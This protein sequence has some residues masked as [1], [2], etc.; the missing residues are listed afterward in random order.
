MK[1]RSVDKE[2][3]FQKRFV[4]LLCWNYIVAMF[5]FY[6]LK[7]KVKERRKKERE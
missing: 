4:D 6:C 2:G 3:G 7:K 1:I 5:L